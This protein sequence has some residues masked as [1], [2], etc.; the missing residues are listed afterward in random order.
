MTGQPLVHF[1]IYIVYGYK[2][3]LFLLLRNFGTVI[4]LPSETIRAIDSFSLRTQKPIQII[5]IFLTYLSKTLV[6]MY[7]TVCENI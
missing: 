6:C 3:F 2:T 1:V 5:K 7:C 4:R